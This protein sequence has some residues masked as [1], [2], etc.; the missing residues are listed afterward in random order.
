[1]SFYHTQDYCVRC[2]SMYRIK[3]VA[4]DFVWACDCQPPQTF[5]TN[6]TGPP[7]SIGVARGSGES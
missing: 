1:M 7:Q 4:G 5:T 3:P 2:G 6:N